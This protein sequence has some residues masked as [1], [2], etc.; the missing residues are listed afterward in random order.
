MGK[1]T[2]LGLV[3]AVLCV[4][5]GECICTGDSHSANCSKPDL[6]ALFDF[7]SGLN[8]PENR[9]SSW[10]GSN[11]YQWNGIGR[12]NSTG[13]VIMIDLQNPYPLNSESS[14]RFRG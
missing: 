1:F 4:I 6:E 13:A 11:H 3:L 5:T 8:D 12:N 2:V 10:Q 14:S 7:E 9:L